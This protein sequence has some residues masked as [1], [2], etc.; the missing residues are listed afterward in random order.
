MK[1]RNVRVSPDADGIVGR[2]FGWQLKF[3][4]KLSWRCSAIG[5]YDVET[6]RLAEG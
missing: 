4:Q 6:L 5:S 1:L 2:K 3:R